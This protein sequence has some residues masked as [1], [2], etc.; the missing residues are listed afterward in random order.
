MAGVCG[1]PFDRLRAV[2]VLAAATWQE[3]RQSFF[4]SPS[5][6]SAAFSLA[7]IFG[8]KAA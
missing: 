2:S 7:A 8:T 4:A 1:A 6:S 5:F 3:R